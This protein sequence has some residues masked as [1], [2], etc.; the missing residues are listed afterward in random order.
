[1]QSLLHG[2][3]S[4]KVVCVPLPTNVSGKTSLPLKA[5]L[6]LQQTQ[7][8]SAMSPKP[9]TNSEG[10]K[11]LLI[12]MYRFTVVCTQ[13]RLFF[14]VLLFIYS[15]ITYSYC[16]SS[17]YFVPLLMIYPLGNVGWSLNN[18]TPTFARPQ[19]LADGVAAS[20]TA[21]RCRQGAAQRGQQA[22]KK[23]CSVK[24]DAGQV[25]EGEDTEG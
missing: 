19:T 1:M 21:V 6:F 3:N 16:L 17:C 9:G 10:E 24:S 8:L 18:C 25:H 22:R 15:C 5:V 14:L 23:V 2:F 20:C 13:D 4:Q 12:F 7:G 11:W